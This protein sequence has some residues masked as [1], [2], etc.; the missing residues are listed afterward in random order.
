MRTRTAQLIYLSLIRM[1]AS[2][3]SY[4]ATKNS[5]QCN[6][7]YVKGLMLSDHNELS[8]HRQLWIQKHTSLDAKSLFINGSSMGTLVFIIH[9]EL[10]SKG[11]G[12]MTA[13]L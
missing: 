8:G 12:P 2:I 1:I 9:A 5:C 11:K 7:T 4:A 6:G 13:Y 10:I 3:G